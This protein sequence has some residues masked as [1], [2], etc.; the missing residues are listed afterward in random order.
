MPTLNFPADPEENDVWEDNDGVV[1]I[2]WRSAWAQRQGEQ[3][4]FIAEDGLDADP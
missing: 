4:S 2:F 1:W 3:A